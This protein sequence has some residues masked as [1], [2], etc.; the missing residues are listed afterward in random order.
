M[1]Q[2][3]LLPLMLVITQF[4][5][6]QKSDYKIPDSIQN[7]DF[8]YLENRIYQFRN[9]STRAA[10]YLFSY[11]EKAKRER[12][13]RELQNGYQ[14]IVYLSPPA[15]QLVYA[16]SMLYAAKKTEDNDAIGAAFLT[17]GILSFAQKRHKEALDD[18]LIA[19]EYIAKTN[20]HYLI[21]KVKYN[22]AQL[23]NY[24]G[25]Y[26]EAITL[27]KECANYYK[28]NHDR[29]YLNS[30]HS[31]GLSYN[32]M[33]NY[34]MCS[35]TNAE[36]IRE[37]AKRS[38]PEMGVYFR[39]SEGVNQYFL[40][41]YQQAIDYL[42][43]SISKIESNKDFAN[44]AVGN[45]YIGKSYW[46]LKKQETAIPYFNKVDQILNNTQFTRRDLLES[47]VL[48]IN[49]YKTKDHPKLHLYYIDQLLKAERL[50][51]ETNRYLASKVHKEYDNKTYLIEKQK[52]EQQLDKR[53]Y[54][55][56]M[57]IVFVTL[58]F[59]I[60]VFLSYRHYKNNS[61][62]KKKFE[63]LMDKSSEAK[64]ETTKIPPSGIADINPAVAAELIKQ[65]EKW[66]KD[67]KFLDQDISLVKLAA[68]FNSNTKYL[69]L[70]V[71]HYRQKK[72]VTY[73][74]ELKIDYLI[75][76]LQENK[77][78]RKYKQKALADEIGFSSIQRFAHAFRARTEMP[79]SYF[80]AQLLKEE[81]AAAL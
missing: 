33:G 62:Y 23:K 12:N 46:E 77:Q 50:L 45:F 19:N 65:L 54:N 8:R 42:K 61:M 2:N 7:K 5:T 13:W 55:D 14:N 64:K 17:K 79:A 39:H 1:K 18:Y 32:K 20:D 69:S 63:A 37:S 74:N 15:V 16:D 53:K 36:G 9:D 26:D 30:L 27:L 73:V 34:G 51:H 76:A 41:N 35:Q 24:M 78:L 11:L 28:K 80:I 52:L 75:Q 56:L 60:L 58:L 4:I 81:T 67:K 59:L 3:Y 49:Y 43:N 10:L 21:Y 72:F 25:F 22:M 48:L 70:I 66:E 31:L 29:P 68:S 47:Y 38:V 40:K 71:Y 44:E 57:F 6:A